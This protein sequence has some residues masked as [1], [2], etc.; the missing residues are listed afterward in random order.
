MPESQ[1]P[2]KK[3]RKSENFAGRDGSAMLNGYRFSLDLGILPPTRKV[4]I[5]KLI[6]DNGGVVGLLNA[7][8][9]QIGFNF[10]TSFLDPLPGL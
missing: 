6:E 9:W 8:V 3:I 5:K 7:Q 2:N 10:L 4:A 1:T